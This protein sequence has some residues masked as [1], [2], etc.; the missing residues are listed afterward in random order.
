VLPKDAVT[1]A[2]RFAQGQSFV[3]RRWQKII[4]TLAG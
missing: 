2:F 4:L 1:A 3:A